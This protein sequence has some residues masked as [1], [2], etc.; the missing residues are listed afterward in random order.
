MIDRFAITLDGVAGITFVETV[1]DVAQQFSDAQMQN[2]NGVMPIGC[3][4]SCE[5]A[6]V[7]FAHNADPVAGALG[8]GVL[9]HVL[10]E[11]QSMVIQNSNS[12]ANFRYLHMTAQEQAYLQVT[13]YYQIGS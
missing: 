2:A 3:L 7:R 12:I 5:G 11:N 10:F 8:S 4:I 6:N 13:M 1:T 9:G